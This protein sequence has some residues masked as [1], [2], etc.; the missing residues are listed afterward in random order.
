MLYIVGK[1]RSKEAHLLADFLLKVINLQLKT[2]RSVPAINL[3]GDLGQ[4]HAC[5]YALTARH[6]T[7]E[8]LLLVSTQKGPLW[9]DKAA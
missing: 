1:G 6:D 7:Y 9:L 4:P 5:T 2:M 3:L 8:Y